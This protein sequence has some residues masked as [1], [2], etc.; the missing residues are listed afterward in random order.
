MGHSRTII[1]ALLAAVATGCVADA[2]PGDNIAPLAEDPPDEME[3]IVK[4]DWSENTPSSQK[5]YHLFECWW[6]GDL[7]F[8]VLCAKANDA[9]RFAC[10]EE[11]GAGVWYSWEGGVKEQRMMDRYWLI[12]YVGGAFEE[13]DCDEPERSALMESEWCP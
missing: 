9:D 5:G 10:S 11:T 4:P 7:S 12:A 1:L 3:C 8:R 6:N 2:A 13:H